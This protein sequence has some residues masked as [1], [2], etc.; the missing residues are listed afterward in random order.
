MTR[1]YGLRSGPW[2]LIPMTC[3]A[4]GR[5]PGA[6]R[7]VDVGD[8]LAL[9][10]AGELRPGD[11]L[12]GSDVT[13]AFLYRVRA[14]LPA[15]GGRVAVRVEGRG[16]SMLDA[17]LTVWILAGGDRV[18]GEARPNYMGPE[19]RPAWLALGDD[20]GDGDGHAI[21]VAASAGAPV[22]WPWVR[23]RFTVDPTGAVWLGSLLAIHDDGTE[24]PA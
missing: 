4:V 22:R 16:L 21:E 1:R 5:H 10:H 13:G 6:V 11:M 20:L 12:Q 14:V 18:S 8:R 19:G 23:E 17:G 7:A 24:V 3:D 9:R 2:G 15:S